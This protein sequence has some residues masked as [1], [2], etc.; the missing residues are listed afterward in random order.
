MAQLCEGYGALPY[1]GAI[2][3]QPLGLLL[4]GMACRRYVAA[5]AAYQRDPEHC[6]NEVKA[7]VLGIA[8]AS[9]EGPIGS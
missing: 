1:P 8:A 7:W 2:V 6:P 3:D 9:V 5:Y 4:D